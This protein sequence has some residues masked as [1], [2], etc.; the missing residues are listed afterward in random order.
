MLAHYE[1]LELIPVDPR[2]WKV[3]VPGAAALAASLHEH[4]E[5]ALLYRQLATLRVDVPLPEDIDGLLWKGARRAE[6]ESLCAEI[7]DDGILERVHRW[8]V[9]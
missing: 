6:L 4:R 9:P 3:A 1:H 7:G 8:R 2:E 5:A